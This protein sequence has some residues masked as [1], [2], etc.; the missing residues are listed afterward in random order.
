MDCYQALDLALVLSVE[1]HF[2]QTGRWHST[3]SAGVKAQS[4]GH[5]WLAAAVI[6]IDLFVQFQ[7][8]CVWRLLDYLHLQRYAVAE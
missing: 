1:G 8:G 7:P 4:H 5:N 6:E 3:A 2:R